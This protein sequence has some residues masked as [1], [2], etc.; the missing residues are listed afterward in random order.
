M[1]RRMAC[2]AGPK[3]AII[4]VVLVTPL[5]AHGL[6]EVQYRLWGRATGYFVVVQTSSYARPLMLPLW[7]FA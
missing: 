6:L 2:A 7:T 3:R 4:S 1:F 5:N